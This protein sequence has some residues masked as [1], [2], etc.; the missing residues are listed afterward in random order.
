MTFLTLCLYGTSAS[1]MNTFVES[2][3]MVVCIDFFSAP[4]ELVTPPEDISALGL[5]TVTFS[6]EVTADPEISV[7]WLWLQDGQEVDIENEDRISVY[8]NGTLEIREISF[9]DS[10]LYT[11]YVMSSLNNVSSSAR[12]SIEGRV[13][14]DSSA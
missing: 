1:E 8:A 7:S 6:C 13:K 2:L 5:T 12:L 4:T 11:C 14:Y 3:L 10:G 9:E